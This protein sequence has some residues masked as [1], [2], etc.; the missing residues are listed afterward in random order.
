MMLL[1]EFT[2]NKII[3]TPTTPF[4]YLAPES[5]ALRTAF[6]TSAVIPSH[7]GDF[8]V[9]KAAVVCWFLLTW[10]T[11]LSSEVLGWNSLH[12]P[13]EMLCSHVFLKWSCHCV[14]TSVMFVFL[15][16]FLPLTVI[17]DSLGFPSNSFTLL[18]ILWEWFV[19]CL[20]VLFQRFDFLLE[21]VCL[22]VFRVGWVLHHFISCRTYVGICFV[23]FLT[24]HFTMQ[25][26]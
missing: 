8:L 12:S 24:I 15:F 18:K 16:P 1:K 19:L 14:N 11:S 7:P 21:N 25:L 17:K 9:F 13:M 3:R 10:Y 5:T 6:S 2:C 22:L 26:Q 20:L 4:A 23:L